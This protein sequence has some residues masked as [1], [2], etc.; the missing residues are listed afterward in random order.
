MSCEPEHPALDEDLVQHLTEA[1]RSY[2]LGCEVVV[3]DDDGSVLHSR[4]NLSRCE[5]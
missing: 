4:R 2:R 5:N 1:L 3:I